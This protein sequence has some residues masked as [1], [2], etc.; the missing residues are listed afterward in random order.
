MKTIK[1]K[2]VKKVILFLLLG[3]SFGGF[4]QVG[5]GT[6]DPTSQ[7]ALD[8]RTTDKGLLIPR[9][10]TTQ[11]TTLKS[12]LTTAADSNNKG[13]QVF[14]TDLNSIY[15]W[16]GTEWVKVVEDIYTVTNASGNQL[17]VGE[18]VFIQK[19]EITITNAAKIL[20]GATTTLLDDAPKVGAVGGSVN[21]N[22]LSTFELVEKGKISIKGVNLTCIAGDEVWYRPFEAVDKWGTT[23]GTTGNAIRLGY[24]M[25]NLG[26]NTNFLIDFNP[27]W[28][29][30]VIITSASNTDH[31]PVIAVN[32]N[33]SSTITRIGRYTVGPVGINAF[34]GKDNQIADYDGSAFVF[35]I[36]YNGYRVQVV[37]GTE[38]GKVYVYNGTAWAQFSKTTPIAIENYA[39]A[40]DYVANDLVVRNNKIYQ[41]NA[42]IIAN[43]AFAIGTTTNWKKVS[44]ISEWVLSGVY[45]TGD[46]VKKEAVLY[47]ANGNISTNTAFVLGTSGATWKVVGGASANG[48]VVSSGSQLNLTSAFQVVPGLTFTVPSNGIYEINALL[49]RSGAES[50]IAVTFGINGVSQDSFTQHFGYGTYENGMTPTFVT[51]TLTAG[52]IITILARNNDGTNGS[53]LNDGSDGSNRRPS[54]RWKKIAD[55]LPFA[56]YPTVPNWTSA[57]AVSVGATSNAPNVPATSKNAVYYKQIGVRTWQVELVLETNTQ[58]GSW[59]GNGDY[60]LTLPNGLTFDTSI[61][62]QMIYNSNIGANTG[63]W[64]S[65]IL[66]N[67]AAM[68]T[69]DGNAS[70][71]SSGGVIPYSSSQYRVYLPNDSANQCWG[72]SWFQFNS[73]SNIEIKISFTFQSAY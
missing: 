63:T 20:I 56:M 51:N 9:L 73:G 1:I 64:A 7:A 39:Q 53:I 10:S 29:S 4:S 18:L 34:L 36:P 55:Y 61:Q 33:N 24:A 19:S 30:E 17:S 22:N 47:E 57:G 65:K 14:D 3:V 42:N 72:S 6:T 70:R 40:N 46:I 28:A 67:S 50:R 26:T 11:R 52:Q 37:E 35:T 5:I 13:M 15:F 21:V 59:E 45:E 54:I 2:L 60:L 31:K 68:I 41:A 8:I 12:T 62:T 43:T 16:N 38:I 23:A 66:A 69:R 32:V 49:V 44:E 27:Q 25:T 58:S 71:G 48:S